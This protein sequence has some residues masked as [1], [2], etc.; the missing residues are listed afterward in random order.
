MTYSTL[1][2]SI[3]TMNMLTIDV[4]NVVDS[5]ELRVPLLQTLQTNRAVSKISVS[6]MLY[7]L[8][9]SPG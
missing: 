7:P 1:P 3:N 4:L 6:P 2:I 5:I 9:R 8:S